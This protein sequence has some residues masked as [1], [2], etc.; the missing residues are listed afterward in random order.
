MY[1]LDQKVID[2]YKAQPELTGARKKLLIKICEDFIREAKVTYKAHQP[3]YSYNL[4]TQKIQ[5]E[6]HVYE[7]T[8]L[9]IE[10]GQM[11]QTLTENEE[12]RLERF[13]K[14]IDTLWSFGTLPEMEDIKKFVRSGEM[15]FSLV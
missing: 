9:K 6:N 5:Q 10:L 1:K 4:R 7:Y 15:T 8:D 13:K 12:S 11:E 3:I 2:F 14:I